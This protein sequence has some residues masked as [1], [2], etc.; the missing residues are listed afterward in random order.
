MEPG[1]PARMRWASAHSTLT[2]PARA[3]DEVA[4]SIAESLGEGPVDLALAFFTAPLAA[5]AEAIAVALRRALAPVTLAGVSARGVVTRTREIEQGA[6]LS[7][8]AARLPGVDVRPFLLLQE[9]WREP[10]ADAAAFDRLA[11]GARE[12]ELVLFAGDP[13]SLGVERVLEVF[14]RH[15][16][17]V[18]VV[19]GLASAAGRPRGNVLF[20]NDWV[21]SEGGFAIALHGALRADVVVSQGCAP[22]GPALEVTAAEENLILTLDGRPALERA[23]QVLRELPE[24]ER[25]RLEQGLY[26][27][28]PARGDAS[29]SGDWLI[30]NLLGADRDRG[31]LAVGD[32]VVAHEKIRLHVRDARAA[33]ADLELLLTPQ[34]FDSRAEGVLLFVCN[35]RGRMLYGEPDRDITTL[36]GALGG[37]LPAGGMFC[38]GEI[39]PVGERN[40]LHGHTASIA[41]VRPR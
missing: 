30:R 25:S 9:A 27:G 1:A 19:G 12:A 37:P 8:V 18:R 34:A 23:E 10:V 4:A 6:A 31:V 7:V 33:A 35:G 36:Q 29:G 14:N 38:A 22:I 39:G 13:Y 41:I 24:A 40:F 3:A 11:P 21:S 2:D 5:N 16:P 15:A 26:V 17:G 32:R 20:L 28:R